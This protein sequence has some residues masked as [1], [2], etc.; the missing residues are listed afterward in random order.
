MNP[1]ITGPA[2]LAYDI[3]ATVQVSG[4]GRTKIYEAI[5]NGQ[6]KAHKHGTRTLILAD[7][8]RA[9]LA[10]LPVMGAA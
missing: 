5:K 10:S 3:P 7:D 4:I 6:L 9:Y 8:L 1:L 2:P